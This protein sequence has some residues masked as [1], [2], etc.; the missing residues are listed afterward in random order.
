MGRK[1][2][3]VG[4][5]LLGGCRWRLAGTFYALGALPEGEELPLDQ[6]NWMHHAQ[7]GIDP[8]RHRR[9]TRLEIRPCKNNEFAAAVVA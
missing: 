4:G 9:K 2:G 6:R 3:G 1:G 5:I 7:P 8:V